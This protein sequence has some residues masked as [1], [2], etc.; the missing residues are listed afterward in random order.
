MNNRR[1]GELYTFNLQARSKKIGQCLFSLFGDTEE[2]EAFLCAFGH[3][4]SICQVLSRI[5]SCIRQAKVI[6]KTVSCV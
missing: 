5:L 1:D 2:W 3:A 6:D 4:W